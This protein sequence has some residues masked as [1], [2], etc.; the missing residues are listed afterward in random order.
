MT[1]DA[2]IAALMCALAYLMGQLVGEPILAW[3]CT[4]IDADTFWT[5]AGRVGWQGRNLWD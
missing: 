5:I 4:A 3:A 1:D 2:Y